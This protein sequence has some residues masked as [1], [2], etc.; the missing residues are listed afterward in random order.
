M[1]NILH[2]SPIHLGLA[3]EQRINELGMTKSEFGRKIGTSKQNVTSILRK[4]S[5]DTDYLRKY[6]EV[7]NFNFFTLFCAD[8]INGN[9]VD[10]QNNHGAVVG[11]DINGASNSPIKLVGCVAD[12]TERIRALETLLAERESQLEQV[13]E[14]ANKY[15]SMIEKLTNK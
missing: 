3:I 1:S 2:T 12:S 4:R 10:A 5:M 13:S 9:K 7:L 11:R 8:E 14:R 6:G 15:W